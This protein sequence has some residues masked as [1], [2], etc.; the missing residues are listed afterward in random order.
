MSA[1]A[2]QH[3]KDTRVDRFRHWLQRPTSHTT[4]ALITFAFLAD[5]AVGLWA[6]LEWTSPTTSTLGEYLVSTSDQ[7]SVWTGRIFWLVIIIFY[8]LFP[9]I[10]GKPFH[11]TDWPDVAQKLLNRGRN[12]LSS[13]ANA[14][15][16]LTIEFLVFVGLLVASFNAPQLTPPPSGHLVAYRDRLLA[17]HEGSVVV[18]DRKSFKPIQFFPP[19]KSLENIAGTRD[20]KRIFATDF[21]GGLHVLSTVTGQEEITPP[22]NAGK[23]ASAIALSADGNKLYVGIQGPPPEGEIR[24]YYAMNLNYKSSIRGVGCPINLFAPSKTHLLFVAT[25]CGGGYDPLYIIDTRSDEIKA[26]VPGF[27]VGSSVVTSPDGKKVF[28]ST[29]DNF[30]SVDLSGSPK[31]VAKKSMGVG[32][33]AITEDGS[34][35]LVGSPPGLKVMAVESGRWCSDVPLEDAPSAIAI[36]PDGAVFVQLQSRFFVTD[37]KALNCSN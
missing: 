12:A 19:I 16:V 9:L 18:L 8:V 21:D 23:S 15:T 28:V 4:H 30:H 27:A 25:Q 14:S 5:V 37:A 31:I 6:H 17:I 24:I 11:I 26:K 2:K 7:L 3:T 32:P 33:M 36:T 22:I 20:A 10:R 13:R 34:L 29:G 1:N 35:L